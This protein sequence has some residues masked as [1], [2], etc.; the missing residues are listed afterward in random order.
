MWLVRSSIEYTRCS[1][2]RHRAH[3]HSPY[4]VAKYCTVCAMGAR[5]AWD[6][7][8]SSTLSSC[9]ILNIPEFLPPWYCP[10]VCWPPTSWSLSAPMIEQTAK[11]RQRGTVLWTHGAGDCSP[12]PV[13]RWAAGRMSA[14][15][16]PARGRLEERLV[17][18]ARPGPRPERRRARLAICRP[19]APTRPSAEPLTPLR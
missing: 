6:L 13:K 12:C 18:G 2:I 4:P 5:P 17:R 14:D 8:R 9:S 3:S 7:D 15:R 19:E 1:P 10:A 11:T 16:T